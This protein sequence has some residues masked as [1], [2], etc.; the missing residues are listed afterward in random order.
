MVSPARSR[1]DLVA[2]VGWV[3]L[4]AIAFAWVEASVVVYLRDLYYPQGFVFPLKPFEASRLTIELIR[5][6]ATLIMLAAVGLLAGQTRWERFGCFAIAFGIWDLFFY[7]WLKVAIDWPSS[8]FDWD[9]LFLLPVPWIGP[10]V[11]PVTVSLLLVT[12]GAMILVVE[13]SR[14]FRPGRTAWTSALLGSLFILWS[15]MR[16][17]DAGMR[18]ATPEPF[19]YGLFWMGAFLYGLAIV[20]SWNLSRHDPVTSL[21]PQRSM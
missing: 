11:A 16:D 14:R 9:I 1:N 3:A 21:D 10:V 7:L 5:E 2:T 15:F 6:F 8:I 12:G 19:W 17:V 20:M 4:F 13:R 18:G